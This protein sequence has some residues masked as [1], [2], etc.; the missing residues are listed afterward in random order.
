MADSYAKILAEIAAPAL[1]KATIHLEE[2]VILI[3]THT[4]DIDNTSAEGVTLHTRNGTSWTFDEVVLTAPLGWLKRHKYDAFATPLPDPILHSI[5]NISFSRLE[6]VYLT[7][8]E[9]WWE[10]N[11]TPSNPFPTPYPATTQFLNPL[12]A[13]HPEGVPWNQTMLNL[14]AL[15]LTPSSKTRNPTLL[16]YLYGGCSAHFQSLLST[17]SANTSI[18]AG[19]PLFH[20]I[21]ALFTPFL[22]VLPHYSPSVSTPLSILPTSH[23]TSPFSYGS[24]THLSPAT[25]TNLDTDISTLRKGIGRNTGLW[26]AG[27]H[28][29]PF[30]AIG[31]TT[32]A[33]WSGEGVARRVLAEYGRV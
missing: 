21:L 14:A 13:S 24:Y 10:D 32:G 31:T 33:Y 6:K 23:S 19:D 16:F 1:A 18:S 20:R 2:E 25:G 3:D 9:A 15:P 26:F 7:F 5:E 22:R 17:Q 12:Y 8:S 4:D 11:P 27:E 29:A 30:I 28:T